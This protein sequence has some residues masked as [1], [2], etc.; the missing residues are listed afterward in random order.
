MDNLF[1]TGLTLPEL[2]KLFRS[3]LESF[4]SEQDFAHSKS[5]PDVVGIDG[6]CEVTGLAKQTVYGH[7]SNR[8]IP[9]SKRGGR[10]YF[11]R[12]DLEKWM[13]SGRKKTIAEI[14]A[15]V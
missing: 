5:G 1:L 3:E 7:V 9:H 15:E 4:F 12:A 6:A 14:A 10:L 2:K 11:S 13:M 8:T